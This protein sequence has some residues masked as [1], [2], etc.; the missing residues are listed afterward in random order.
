MGQV[1][2]V[3]SYCG[4]S[5][6]TFEVN[7]SGRALEHDEVKRLGLFPDKQTVGRHE[8]SNYSQEWFE[9]N[10]GDRI[11]IRSGE[12]FEITETVYEV[13]ETP[14]PNPPQKLDDTFT[15][16]LVEYLKEHCKQVS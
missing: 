5:N 13:P 15:I 2:L 4:L 16:N 11:K 10:P 6:Y 1:I 14:L 7:V 3:G 8:A 12:D 9:V